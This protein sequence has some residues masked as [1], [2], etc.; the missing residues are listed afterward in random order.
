[1]DIRYNFTDFNHIDCLSLHGCVYELCKCHTAINTK[2]M[3]ANNK[4]H[5]DNRTLEKHILHLGTL[6]DYETTLTC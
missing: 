2:T 4:Y 1:M 6:Q 5:L 3:K